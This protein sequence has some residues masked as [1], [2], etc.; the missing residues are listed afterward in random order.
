MLTHFPPE[1]TYNSNLHSHSLAKA[2]DNFSEKAVL[3]EFICLFGVGD[4]GG[5]PTENQIERGV[6]MANLDGCPRLSFDRA[7]NFFERLR[8]CEDDLQ[9]WV[10]E[11]Y[12]ELHRGTLTT[13][14]LVKKCNRQLEMQLRQLEILW[15]CLPLNRYPA[16]E[17][18]EIWKKVLLN[19]FHDILPGSSI[20][21]VYRFTHAEYDNLL[22]RCQALQSKAADD[23]FDKEE[24]TIVLFNSLSFPYHGTIE[25]PEEWRGFTAQNADSQQELPQQVEAGGQ[26]SIVSVSVPP[27]SFLSIRK[28]KQHQQKRPRA[29]S[30]LILENDLM[31]SS[32]L[33]TKKCS[34]K[35]YR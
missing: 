15:S 6:R 26:K 7:D 24:D 21:E 23:L 25:L 11:L 4:G 10:G 28:G 19:Q 31:R 17:L 27:L 18:D 33:S 20:N 8:K 14:A 30:E 12:L 5:G 9:T 35:L 16:K 2:R 34:A 13:Q 1:D 3:D 22:Q 32:G 29:V